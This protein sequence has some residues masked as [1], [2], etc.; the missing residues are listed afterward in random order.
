MK[1]MA[2]VT[3]NP[4]TGEAMEEDDGMS[5]RE[6]LTSAWDNLGTGTASQ[7]KGQLESREAKLKREM[8]EAGA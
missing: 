1:K 4:K 6:K 3:I 2:K 7:A 8:E 5:L